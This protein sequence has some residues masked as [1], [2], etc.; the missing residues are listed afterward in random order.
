[1]TQMIF[2]DRPVPLS[3]ERHQGLRLA[4][5]P[6]HHRFAASTHLVPLTGTELQD[7]ARDYPVLFASEPGGAWSMVALLGLRPSHNL[8]VDPQ[9][10][11][12]PGTYIPAFVR[13]YP[14]VLATAD[15]SGQLTVCVDEACAGL[16][17]ADGEPL[18]TESQQESDFLKAML[19]FLQRF[20]TEAQRTQV[21]IQRLL[22][23]DLLVPKTI[24]VDQGAGQAR[25]DGLWVVDLARYRQLPDEQV[26]TLF[27]EGE[28]SWVEAHLFSMGQLSRLTE[29]LAAAA[30]IPG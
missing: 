11:W 26:L 14:F 8:M 18:F 22:A 30:K 7:A 23:L 20:H 16:N 10:Q 3:R 21:F 25:V 17:P 1:M 19:G 5:R 24:N 6:N 2:Y 28:L 29:R 13:R 15:G 4:M 9:G 27:R 12:Q